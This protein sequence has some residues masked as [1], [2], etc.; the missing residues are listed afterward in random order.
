MPAKGRSLTC[1]SHLL[2]PWRATIPKNLRLRIL[3][4]VA[5]MSAVPAY[6]MLAAFL[7]V[8]NQKKRKSLLCPLLRYASRILVVLSAKRATA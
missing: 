3:L 7:A 2:P 5:S 1:P 4:I 6:V 8:G